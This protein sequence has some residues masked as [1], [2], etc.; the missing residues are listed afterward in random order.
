MSPEYI[1]MLVMDL[2]ALLAVL[3]G[4]LGILLEY[5]HDLTSYKT[6]D[7]KDHLFCGLSICNLLNGLSRVVQDFFL[8]LDENPIL[9]FNNLGF[10]LIRLT[11]MPCVLFFSTWLSVYFCLK[12]VNFNHRWYV[13]LQKRFRE[14]FPWLLI[15]SVVGSVVVS[16]PFAFFASRFLAK[17]TT[18]IS[19]YGNR[20]VYPVPSNILTSIKCYIVLSSLCFIL[21]LS[22]SCPIILSLYQHMKK[23][24]VSPPGSTFPTLQ[25]HITAVK[26]I[27]LL[28]ILNAL[29]FISVVLFIL[30]GGELTVKYV[31]LTIFNICH[32]TSVV[33]L[34]RGN[35]K[36]QDNLKNTVTEWLCVCGLKYN[37]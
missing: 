34:F 32:I 3:P 15:F 6:L 9:M 36:V 35:S 13:G 27:T 24:Q 37:I 11:T 7:I 10:L 8:I 21:F 23:I 5:F 4:H 25:P 1:G 33:I 18:V 2:T 31:T 30:S 29:Y 26:T 17:Q 19:S 12:I 28:T 14:I 22:S 20:T 16:F